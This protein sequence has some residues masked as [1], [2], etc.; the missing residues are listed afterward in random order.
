M[1][2]A[3]GWRGRYLR[4]FA[5]VERYV[6]AHLLQYPSSNPLFIFARID[7]LII[8]L[9]AAVSPA[10]EI[11][12]KVE[13]ETMLSS[14][15]N[16]HLK[17]ITINLTDSDSISH[18]NLYGANPLSLLSIV[19][20]NSSLHSV[21]VKS[22]N[23]LANSL[24]RS[25]SSVNSSSC[26]NHSQYYPNNNQLYTSVVSSSSQSSFSSNANSRHHLSLG[27]S[28]SYGSLSAHSNTTKH[29]PPHFNYI[30]TPTHSNI[31]HP[32]SSSTYTSS[33]SPI[34]L[35]SPPSHQIPSFHQSLPPPSPHATT[36]MSM[37]SFAP[38]NTHIRSH[39]SSITSNSPSEHVPSYGHVYGHPLVI[40]SSPQ[41]LSFMQQSHPFPADYQTPSSISFS[42]SL[43]NQQNYLQNPQSSFSFNH[44]ISS[45]QNNEKSTYPIHHSPFTN[46]NIS[47]YAT[48]EHHAAKS[49]MHTPPSFKNASPQIPIKDI[50]ESRIAPT[51]ERAPELVDKNCE[52]L[53]VS[54]NI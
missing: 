15:S 44:H 47:N 38:A 33:Y 54:L 24:P 28:S 30:Q 31:L 45:I 7:L 13:Q 12:A 34:H 52:G 43:N 22:E 40:D 6:F 16:I 29:L 17:D 41:E 21:N 14:H 46:S 23:S 9:E 42:D 26:V 51:P 5:K 11:S 32:S 19:S 20:S 48:H 1:L 18:D 8:P 2:Q 53:L 36:R 35:H 27:P 25:Q 10:A 39:A 4:S 50:Y 3:I 37:P 49:N